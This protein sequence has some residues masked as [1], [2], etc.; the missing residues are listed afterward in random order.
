MKIFEAPLSKKQIIEKEKG[1]LLPEE[2]EIV[3]RKL[4]TII[5]QIREFKQPINFICHEAYYS[6]MTDRILR[7]LDAVMEEIKSFRSSTYQ[8]EDERIL[9]EEYDLIATALGKKTTL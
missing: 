5:M 9:N 4:V 7:Q 8:K 2:W 3:E 1:T 6:Q